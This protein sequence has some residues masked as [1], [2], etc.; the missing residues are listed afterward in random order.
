M[1]VKPAPTRIICLGCAEI[2][3]ISAEGDACPCCGFNVGGV[4]YWKIFNYA[5]AAVDYGYSYREVY[6]EELK[7]SGEIS[8]YSLVSLGDAFTWMALAA[9]SGI[10]GGVSW[11]LA[12][13]VVRR[14]LKQ[15]NRSADGRGDAEAVR[16]FTDQSQFE[17]FALYIEAF[18]WALQDSDPQV[19]S[20]V[21][22]EMVIDEKVRLHLEEGFRG[23]A[24][25]DRAL[26]VE[27]IKGMFR[28]PPGEEA[29]R[30]I[31]KNI[32]LSG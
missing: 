5:A 31:W 4:S 30:E 2:L 28:E 20:A 10:I 26:A 12:G 15:L 17:K 27:R 22:N 32:D 16:V 19:R 6:E 14:I 25:E 29:F 9:L 7:E 24:E 3:P 18:A 23:S 11:E 21:L 1:R 13:A 8:S